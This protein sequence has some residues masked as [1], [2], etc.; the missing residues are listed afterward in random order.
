MVS[1]RVDLAHGVPPRGC[2]GA[3][4]YSACHPHRR[5]STIDAEEISPHGGVV[6]QGRGRE[7]TPAIG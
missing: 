5:E 4:G 7:R 6:E 1:I 2:R 3:L